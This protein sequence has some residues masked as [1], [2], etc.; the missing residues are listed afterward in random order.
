[1]LKQGHEK[2]STTYQNLTLNPDGYKSS[3]RSEIWSERE[4]EVDVDAK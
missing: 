4:I 2:H 3:L 1:M